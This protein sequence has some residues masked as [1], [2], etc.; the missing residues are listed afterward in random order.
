M[1]NNECCDTV[2]SMLLLVM[3]PHV[4]EPVTW[5]NCIRDA[6]TLPQWVINGPSYLEGQILMSGQ[7]DNYRYVTY[8]QGPASGAGSSVPCMRQAPCSRDKRKV[9]LVGVALP[10]QGHLKLSPWALIGPWYWTK[11]GSSLNKQ[12]CPIVL[13]LNN[14]L[15][16]VH[17]LSFQRLVLV[18]LMPHLSLHVLC[19]CSGPFVMEWMEELGP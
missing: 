19:T 11:K 13:G 4:R 2:E 1:R 5:Q 16:D 15:I 10:E 12:E 6:A 8:K 3:G 7:C 17:T 14:I 18:L 9:E